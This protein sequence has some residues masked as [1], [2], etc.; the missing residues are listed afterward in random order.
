MIDLKAAGPQ[1]RFAYQGGL[2]WLAGMSFPLRL[3]YTYDG[4][5]NHQY[6][7]GGIGYFSEGSGLDL[8]YRHE[9]GGDQGQLIALTVKLQL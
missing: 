3:G 1:P 2:E 7:G 6:V 5:G 9:L 8:S 4:I